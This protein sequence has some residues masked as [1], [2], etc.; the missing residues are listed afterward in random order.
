MNKLNGK[1][2]VGDRVII[3]KWYYNKNLPVPQTGIIVN[4]TKSSMD[5]TPYHIKLDGKDH[6]GQLNPTW[7]FKEEEI[8]LIDNNPFTT[9]SFFTGKN[10]TPP[11]VKKVPNHK[12]IELGH[13][14]LALVTEDKVY[15][16]LSA[17]EEEVK[18]SFEEHGED[19]PEYLECYIFNYEDLENLFNSL[20]KITGYVND[21]EVGVLTFE[22]GCQEFNLEYLEY[23]IDTM[24]SL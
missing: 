21:F 23:V 8:T 18:E 14:R 16:F 22:I 19:L 3:H 10:T 20:N 6:W 2:K 24:N 17:T 5:N 4:I 15:F 7:C 1:F 11:E 12:I 13:G 9:K